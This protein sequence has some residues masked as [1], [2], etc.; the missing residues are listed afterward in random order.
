VGDGLVRRSPTIFGPGKDRSHDIGAAVRAAWPRAR[1]HVINDLTSAGYH[2]V[3][4][5]HRDFCVI[6]VGSGIGNKV[7]LDGKP[8]LGSG[9]HGGEIGHL[10]MSPQPGTSCAHLQCELGHLASGRGVLWLSGLMNGADG[11]SEQFVAAY[12]AGDSRARETVR[13][14]A[15]PLAL[16]ISTLH[17]GIGLTRFFVIGG[18]AKALGPDYR[19]MLVAWCRELTW[20]VGQD[21]NSMIE[22]GTEDAEEGL[23]GGAW[24]ASQQLTPLGAVS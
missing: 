6:G 10:R 24:F 7:F 19:D 17:L 18:F 12:R 20:D 9:G 13:A 1:V 14:A 15:H 2:F 3:Q 5:G 23:A 21:W 11:D 8:Q 16:A 4:Q 22:L